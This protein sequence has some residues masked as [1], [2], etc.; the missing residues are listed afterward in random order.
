MSGRG[1]GFNSI[2]FQDPHNH[3]WLVE[4]HWEMRIELMGVDLVCLM[5]SWCAWRAG[6][7]TTAAAW[8]WPR[9]RASA[10]DGSAASAK[11]ASRVGH[12]VRTPRCSC[13]T[14]ATRASTRTASARCSPTSPRWAGSAGIA[15][16]AATAAPGRPGPALPR[17]GTPVSPSATRAINNATRASRAPSAARPID[18]RSARWA[19]VR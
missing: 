19:S 17:G 7:T 13:A 15:A 9:R 14:P 4:C 1:C 16:C 8:G 12:P 3:Y 2:L 6:V 11:C 5:S 10:P 18:T